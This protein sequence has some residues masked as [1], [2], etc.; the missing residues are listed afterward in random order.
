MS[1]AVDLAL[2][3]PGDRHQRWDRFDRADRFGHSL[4]LQVQGVSQRQA[5]KRL[6]VP[7]TTLQAWRPWHATLDICPHVATVFQSELGLAFLHRMVLAFHLVCVEVGA[8]GIRLVCLFLTLTGLD[9]FVAASSG[10][11]QKVNCQ[12]EAAI[13]AYHHTDTARLAKD[14]PLKD[15]ALT[16]A[17]TFTG[18]L[19]LVGAEPVSN[20]IIVETLAQARDQTTWNVLLE[21]ALAQCKGRVIHSTSDEAPG[22]LAYVAP[23][24]GAHHSPDLCHVPH[25]LRKAVASP[26]ATKVRAAHTDASEAQQR[27]VTTHAPRQPTGNESPARGSG[28]SPKE[29]VSLEQAQQTFEGARRE[30]ERLTHQRQQGAQSIR[31]IGPAY[32]CVDL[33]RG[34]RRNGQ[35]IAADM[36]KQIA[37]VRA[38]AQHEGR[39][40]SWLD[41]MEKAQRVVPNM[42]ATLAF[43]SRYVRQQVRQLDL[44]PLASFT[45]HAKLSPAFYLERVARTRT[46]TEGEALRELAVRLRTPLFGP[47]GALSP[48]S[49]EAQEQL[50]HKAKTLAEVFQRSRSNVEGRNGSLSLRNHQLRGLDLPRKRECLTAIHNFFSPGLTG[51]RP[52]SGFSVKSRGRCA[53]RFWL[54]C[55]C[56]P[57]L[58]VH[59]DAPKVADAMI[60]ATVYDLQ[61]CDELALG[62]GIPLDVALRHSQAGMA[63]ELLHVPETPPDL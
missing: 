28:R 62:L 48:L 1:P 25:A 34:V 45:L 13:V 36:R 6:Q 18:G 44:T 40:Q 32:H 37:Q 51:R 53:R 9:R 17:A 3:A 49:P 33:E 50:Q 20:C 5:A 61:E 19:C 31:A 8:C 41:R 14:M 16:Q 46:V 23:P 26:L 35:L 24:L 58:A 2:H 60:E 63:R 7:R 29:P 12:V 30:H 10:A 55:T 47:G 11:Q 42:Q 22:L 38:I 43:V 15:I 39:S 27:L 57:H 4:E 52:R 59:R 21:L 56:H 54:L